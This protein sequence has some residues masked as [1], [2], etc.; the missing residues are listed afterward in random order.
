[1]SLKQL[2][3]TPGPRQTNRIQT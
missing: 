2:K 1:M 3:K